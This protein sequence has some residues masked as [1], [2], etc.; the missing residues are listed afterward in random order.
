MGEIR[1]AVKM[2]PHQKKALA[3]LQDGNILWGGVGSGKSRVALAY[4]MRPRPMRMCMSSPRPRSG[5]PWTGRPRPLASGS[6][7]NAT[8]RLQE[9]DHRLLEQSPQVRGR[10]GSVLHLR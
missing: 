9:S 2:D 3:K 10:E 6:A 4:Y 7:R 8:P 1:T 5:I